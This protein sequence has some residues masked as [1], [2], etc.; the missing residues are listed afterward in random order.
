MHLW[1][2]DHY[3]DLCV[4]RYIIPKKGQ[5]YSRIF[6]ISVLYKKAPGLSSIPDAF[7]CFISLLCPLLFY[8]PFLFFTEFFKSVRY[9][10]Q[11]KLKVLFML[12]YQRRQDNT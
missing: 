4:P 9:C 10:A 8:F 11:F 12:M 6:T 2:P 1:Q 3:M 7:H 5:T